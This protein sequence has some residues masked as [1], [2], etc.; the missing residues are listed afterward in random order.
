MTTT[1]IIPEKLQAMNDE[2][3]LTHC[4]Q[5]PMPSQWSNYKSSFHRD[6]RLA[7]ICGKKYME[8]GNINS[9]KTTNLK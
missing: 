4:R 5:Y 6:Y 2:E 1:D 3:F 8:T 7:Q 9:F